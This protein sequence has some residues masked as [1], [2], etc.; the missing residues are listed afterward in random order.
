MEIGV[1]YIFLNIIFSSGLP[2]LNG[3]LHATEIANM[4]LDL[5]A[6]CTNLVIDFV[7]GKRIKLRIGIHSGNTEFK[8]SFLVEACTILNQ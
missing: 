1:Q 3:N 7:P 4:A 6:C 5:L 2:R 8:K